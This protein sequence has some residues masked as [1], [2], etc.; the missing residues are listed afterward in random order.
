MAFQKLADIYDAIYKDKPYDQEVRDLLK[1]IKPDMRVLD[2]GCGTG[3]H[4]KLL[5]RSNEVVGIEPSKDMAAIARGK[6]LEV[7][8]TTIEAANTKAFEPFDA[9]IAMFDVLDYV[10]TPDDFN[11]AMTNINHILKPDGLFFYEGW[12]K[13][14]INEAFDSVRLKEF[15]YQ[16]R[17]WNRTSYVTQENGTYTI[18]YDYDPQSKMIKGFTETHVMHPHIGSVENDLSRWGLARTRIW[19]DTYSVK[20]WYKKVRNV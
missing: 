11:K 16:G 9:V 18:Q 8:V 6:G 3:K 12:N 17:K 2:I 5:S 14:T 20:A 13:N 15:S 7:Y 19:F 4:M 1:M 10:V